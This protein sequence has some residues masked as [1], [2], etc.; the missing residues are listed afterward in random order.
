MTH[1][2]L[3]PISSLNPSRLLDFMVSESMISARDKK[4]VLSEFESSEGSIFDVLN[5]HALGNETEILLRIAKSLET[6][7]IDLSSFQLKPE[8]KNILSGELARR[9]GALPIEFTDNHIRVVLVDPLNIEATEALRFAVD[10]NLEVLIANPNQIADLIERAYADVPTNKIEAGT[11]SDD[12]RLMPCVPDN[13]PIEKGQ[14]HASFSSLT[15]LAAMLC[16][17]TTLSIFSFTIHYWHL[18]GVDAV[19]RRTAKVDNDAQ[20]ALMQMQSSVDATS[21]QL[22]DIES[23][24]SVLEKGASVLDD[25]AIKDLGQRLD[26]L[27]STQGFLLKLTESQG[28]RENVPDD[29]AL[30]NAN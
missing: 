17:I 22:A 20:A 27:E 8:C 11:V 21:S 28:V 24:L 3:F 26:K 6:Q 5:K 1:E 4:E 30:K 25:A 7:V 14:R 18:N 19:L 10:S 15:A 12:E 9:Y 2:K 29:A 16:L 13:A 23:K